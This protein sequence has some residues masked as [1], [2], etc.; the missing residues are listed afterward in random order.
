MKKTKRLKVE[1]WLLENQDIIN[2]TGI[3][4][5]IGAPKGTIQKFLKYNRVLNDE[6]IEILYKFLLK[7]GINNQTKRYR[8]K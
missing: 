4:K 6:R 5:R 8:L 1:V 3:D 7:T 2:A